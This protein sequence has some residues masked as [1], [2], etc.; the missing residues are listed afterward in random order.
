MDVE[1]IWDV[2]KTKLPELKL[3]I[4][5]ILDDLKRNEEIR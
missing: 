4:E 3:R 5:Q 1:L 2:V